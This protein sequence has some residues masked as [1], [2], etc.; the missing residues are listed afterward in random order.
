MPVSTLKLSK[1][2]RAETLTAVFSAVEIESVEFIDAVVPDGGLPFGA[3]EPPSL[4]LF[5]PR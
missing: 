2:R 1:C 3:S 5:H 4:E